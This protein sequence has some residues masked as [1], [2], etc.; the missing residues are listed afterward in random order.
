[1][2]TL[3]RR[4]LLGRTAIAIASAAS[5]HGVVAQAWP[6]RG[7]TLIAPY[8]PGGGVDTVARLLAA[9]HQVADAQER[10]AQEEDA[11]ILA[12]QRLDASR[13]Q[14]RSLERQAQEAAFQSRTLLARQG[15]L[16]RA[17][18]TARQQVAANVQA[19]AQI[20]EVD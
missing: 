14:L 12:Q 16:Q 10:H 6:A 7:I 5:A 4:Q 1:M 8:P 2:Q 19:A 15:E 3:T 11:V 13:E 17:V 18:E 20:D 9:A